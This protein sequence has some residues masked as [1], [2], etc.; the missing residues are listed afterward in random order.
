MMTWKRNLRNSGGLGAL[1]VAAILVLCGGVVEA[2]ER[3]SPPVRSTPRASRPSV[4]PSSPPPAPRPSTPRP[5]T[6]APQ[7]PSHQ[8][9][10]NRGSGSTGHGRG[11]H[12]YGHGYGYRH[13]GFYGYYGYGLYW[14]YH[15][16][17][18][19]YY[20]SHYPYYPWGFSWYPTYRGDTR[21][22]AIKLKIKPKKADVYVDGEYIGR[23]GKYD[24]YPGYLW[25]SEGTHQLVFH[26]EGKKTTERTVR[27]GYGPVR[28]LT[29]TLP[30][31]PS[32]EPEALFEPVREARIVQEKVEEPR[33]RQPVDRER[34]D[35]PVRTESR[36]EPKTF[37]VDLR[38]EPGRFRLEIEPADA[39]VYLDGRFLGRGDRLSRL[40]SGMLV[41]A[42]DHYIEVQR[43]GF[44]TER[45]DF[46]VAA[47]DET[48]LSVN[49]ADMSGVLE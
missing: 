8:Q 15:R 4:R 25:L 14:P 34:R 12:G 20:Y 48:T 46:S 38:E 40:H 11:H 37:E 21:I 29:M 41:Q 44:E 13:H 6:S 1:G 16:F 30:D 43:P 35:E 17:Y 10:P 18:R 26:Y 9:T 33:V 28:R 32:I 19:P 24:G 22:G 7:T 27:V 23:S 3:E 42:G 49:L 39:A 47:G 5:G 2:Q 31:G 45:I 36:D